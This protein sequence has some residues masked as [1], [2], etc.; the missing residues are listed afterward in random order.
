[1]N[2]TVPAVQNTQFPGSGSL[3]LHPS[4]R[5]YQSADRSRSCTA[6]TGFEPSICTPPSLACRYGA[7]VIPWLIFAL[8][9]V[10]LVVAG[11]V[12]MRRRNA[13]IEH[14]AGE[15]AQ[16]RAETER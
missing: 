16:S 13:A 12:A 6:S 4:T 7:R 14:P 10:P 15:D 5:Q 1:M 8:V 2:V 9:A 11:F 3:R